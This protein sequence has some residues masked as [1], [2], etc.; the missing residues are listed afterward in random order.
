[1]AQ[2]WIWFNSLGFRRHPT[3][4]LAQMMSPTAPRRNRDLLWHTY[5]SQA[6]GMFHGDLD[7]YYGG[8]D[9]RAR[10]RGIDTKKCPVYMLTGE[11]DWSSTPE[12]GAATAA[13]IPGAKFTVMS[14]LGHFPAAENPRRFVGYLL[15]AI[16]HVIESLDDESKEALEA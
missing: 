10:V 11:Y 15:G 3:A 2:C 6:Y 7:F 8:W 12:L 16:D 4:D 9:G 13:K 1:M 14:G 5:S